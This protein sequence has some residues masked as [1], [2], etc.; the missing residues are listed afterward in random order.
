MN[1]IIAEALANKLTFKEA[2]NS[3]G[4]E[5][6]DV[7]LNRKKLGK[8]LHAPNYLVKYGAIEGKWYLSYD[9]KD[10]SS[11]EWMH[12]GASSGQD[13]FINADTKE[14]AIAWVKQN[15]DKLDKDAKSKNLQLWPLREN[16][17]LQDMNT[18]PIRSLSEHITE[19]LSINEASVNEDYK[20]A[21]PGDITDL[22]ISA[23]GKPGSATSA[24]VQ[25]V[26]SK[27]KNAKVFH[28]AAYVHVTLANEKDKSDAL[29]MFKDRNEPYINESVNE[30]KSLTFK[31]GDKLT[32]L[33][34][35]NKE[36]E[37]KYVKTQYGGTFVDIDVDGKIV[38]ISKGD[39]VNE[40]KMSKQDTESFTIDYDNMGGGLNGRVDF[41]LWGADEIA[42]EL[43]HY[44]G[45]R[46]IRFKMDSK[47]AQKLLDAKAK[48][49]KMTADLKIG[50]RIPDEQLAEYMALENELSIELTQNMALDL[51]NAASAYEKEIAKVLAKYGFKL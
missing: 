8:I 10:T 19:S 50:E 14:D 47:S 30:A 12:Y 32:F 48:Q 24:F 6:V 45:G 4:I 28:S 33:N 22:T 26:A 36:Q 40:A 49:R 27:F 15:I 44:S 51:K 43:G 29:D 16:N 38:T 37:A 9:V 17:Q 11:R 13:E 7:W 23:K 2:K 3:S 18:N 41:Q 42:I 5:W 20:G 25:N 35:H 21:R 46:N 39:I 34:K 1:N 31:P